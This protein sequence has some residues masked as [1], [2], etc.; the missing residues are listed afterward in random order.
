[1]GVLSTQYWQETWGILAQSVS[2]TQ[3]KAYFPFCEM[4]T[5]T[6]CA[7][8]LV[9]L[10]FVL[11]H[12]YLLCY[13]IRW[14]ISFHTFFFLA[15]SKLVKGVLFFIWLGNFSY[16]LLLLQYLFVSWLSG[17]PSNIARLADISLSTFTLSFS[18][19]SQNGLMLIVTIFLC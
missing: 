3:V 5:C 14:G 10:H 11:L 8:T 1:M 19:C 4:F 15:T 6:L 18:Q 12:L 9:L 2:L 7:T 17:L 13:C 16:G